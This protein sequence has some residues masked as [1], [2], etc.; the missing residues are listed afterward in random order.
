MNRRLRATVATLALAFAV[1]GGGAAPS[2]ASAATYPG[3][4]YLF[5]PNGFTWQDPNPY[6]CTSTS[7][8]DMLNFLFLHGLGGSGFTWRLD[9]NPGTRDAI[10]AWERKNDTLAGGNGSDPHGWRN[11]LNA[12]GW[13]RTAMWAGNRVYED[14]AFSSYDGAVKHAV[15]AMI[16]YRKP[17]GVLAWAGKHAQ[18]IVGFYGL[19]GDPFARDSAGKYTN[20]FTVGGFYLADPLKSQNIVNTRIAYSTYK[21][22]SNLRLRFRPYL[23]TD[24]PYDDPYTAGTRPS[25]DEWYGRFVIISP[26]R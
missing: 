24:S 1:V 11:A 25:R 5:H 14:Y 4:L 22:T 12:W 10:L 18:M 13:G 8:Q 20:A 3:S 19:S 7:V 23:E 17:V 15:R 9:N 16:R 6:A 2:A 26:V 21:S